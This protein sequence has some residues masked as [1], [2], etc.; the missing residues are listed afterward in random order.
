MGIISVLY[1]NDNMVAYSV[2]VLCEA[3]AL[4]R[5]IQQHYELETILFLIL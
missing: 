5:S 1:Q 2:Q 3:P 4:T